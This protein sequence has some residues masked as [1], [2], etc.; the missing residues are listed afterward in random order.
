M[1][2]V[3]GTNNI[4]TI[5]SDK[6]KKAA[7]DRAREVLLSGGIVAFPTE[8]FYGLAVDIKNLEAIEK[9]FKTK[10][11]DKKNP[12]LIILPAIDDL[13]KY[14][15]DIPEQARKFMDK[16]WPGGLTMLFKANRNIS[17]LLTAGTG[18]IGI[19]Y[20]GHPLAI[21]LARSI[22]RPITGTSSNISGQP[23]CTK[24]EEVYRYFGNDIDL[25]LDNGTT[26][27]GPGSTILDVTVIPCK[28]IR[29]G[30]IL[31]DDIERVGLSCL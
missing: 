25:I 22:G 16:F 1:E 24:A 17:P 4:L 6:N 15:E 3:T 7:L 10:K 20:S 29:E 19:R 23:P 21:E 13:K 2:R 26:Q 9:L 5:D 18:K 30:M 14:V 27:G 11:R 12:V 28:F 31:K 8:S